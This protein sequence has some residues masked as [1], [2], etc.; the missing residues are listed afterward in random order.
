MWS[1][2]GGVRIGELLGLLIEKASEEYKQVTM[3]QERERFGGL[4][5]HKS[6]LSTRIHHFNAAERGD[7]CSI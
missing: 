4:Y 1:T 3:D 6:D 7:L 2:S 5:I